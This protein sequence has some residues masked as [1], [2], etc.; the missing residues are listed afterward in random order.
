MHDSSK[1]I[2]L[3]VHKDT[4]AVAVADAKC[5]ARSWGT[6]AHRSAEVAKLVKKLSPHGEVLRFYYEAGPCGYG[7]YR[8][9]TG[10]GHDCRVVAPSLI[11]RKAGDR[12][13]TDRRDAVNLAR[14][15]RAGEL[16]AVWVPDGEQEAMRDLMRC[17]ED[18][19]AAE[20]Q[21]R[22]QLG[23]FLLRHGRTYTA[24]RDKWTATFFHWLEKL[25]FQS[26]VQQI[27]FQEYVDT[28]RSAGDRVARLDTQID[29]ALAGWSL[30]PVVEALMA[31]RGINTVAAMTTVAELGDLTRFASP[32]Q[33][34][35]FLG[36]VPSEHSSGQ[37]TR[38]GRITKS[39]NGHVRRVLT[40]SAWCYRHPARKTAHLRR[41]ARRASEAVQAIAWKAQVRLCGR[42][43]RLIGRGMMPTKVATAIARELSG[44]IW[45]IYQQVM[46][47]QASHRQVIEP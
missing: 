47:E 19:K 37:S 36:L 33:L 5:E 30:R 13:K 8:Q 40:E 18:A 27:V 10:L 34:M 20:R 46:K 45:A 41:K 1:H 3:D 29:E 7:L 25:K 35:S 26:P 23:G 21:A 16:T 6:I 14:L 4:I 2:G 11:P 31:L 22:Q 15:G 39:G 9:L 42:Y 44:F 43:R 28:V 12:V 17:R 32:A 24:G 38:R